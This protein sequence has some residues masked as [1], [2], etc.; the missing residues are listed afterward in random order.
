MEAPVSADADALRDEKVRVL[1]EMQPA[2]PDHLVRGQYHGYQAEP[3]VAAGSTVE[4]Y[5]ALRVEID[6]WRWARVPFFLKAGKALATTALEAVVEFSAP[7]R[8]L[9][10]P[11]GCQ[12]HPNHLRF[13][14]GHDDGVTVS[15]QAK[16]PGERLVSRPVDLDVDFQHVFRVAPDP[17]VGVLGDQ[18]GVQPR[19]EGQRLRWV[20]GVPVD[21][22]RRRMQRRLGDPRGRHA[23][24]MAAGAAGLPEVGAGEVAAGRHGGVEDDVGQHAVG[25]LRTEQRLQLGLGALLVVPGP[26]DRDEGRVPAPLVRVQAAR[27]HR[28]GAQPVV[29]EHRPGRGLQLGGLSRG[30]LAGVG[31]GHRCLLYANR[32]RTQ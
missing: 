19:Q 31:R 5:A 22:K 17:E 14:L 32:L 1:T 27:W 8:L 11:D 13:R 29:V 25:P 28:R 26:P 4:T 12:P 6:S 20:G 9:F 10:S 2:D 3:G 18:L 16:E 15:L 23:V 21:L 7:P 24:G 30:E